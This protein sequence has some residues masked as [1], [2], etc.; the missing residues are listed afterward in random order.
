[1]CRAGGARLPPPLVLIGSGPSAVYNEPV[2]ITHRQHHI[3]NCSF[4]NGRG[5]PL[6]SLVALD[7]PPTYR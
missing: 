7:E 2:A 1:M 4:I 5:D 6:V 3:G